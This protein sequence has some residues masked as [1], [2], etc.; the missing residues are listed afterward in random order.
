MAGTTWIAFVGSVR[1]FLFIAAV[2]FWLG[3]FTFYA[4]VVIH[5]GARALG[6]HMKQGFITQRVTDWLNIAGAAALP[7]MLWNLAAIWR[8]RGRVFRFALAA[9][10]GI[11]LLV[12]VE[13]FALHPFMDRLLDARARGVFDYDRFESLHFAYITSSTVQWTAG[14]IHVWC[15]VAGT[16]V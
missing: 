16:Q 8:V 11:M 5:V 14:L 2:A 12:Q 13:L 15:V 6:S 3:G 1:R 4:G 10:W 7:I 9:S